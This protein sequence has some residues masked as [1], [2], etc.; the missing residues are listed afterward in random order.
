LD[1]NI[2][3][4]EPFLWGR[5]KRQYFCEDCGKEIKIFAARHSKKCQRCNLLARMKKQREIESR[6]GA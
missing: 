5:G 2:E 1:D 6:V 3:K 4:I